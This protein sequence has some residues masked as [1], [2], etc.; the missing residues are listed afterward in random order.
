MASAGGWGGRL[1]GNALCGLTEPKTNKPNKRDQTPLTQQ[2]R[3]QRQERA[4]ALRPDPGPS[5]GAGRQG[6][7]GTT[8]GTLL[9]QHL[10]RTRGGG[11]VGAAEEMD[12]RESI[13]RHAGKEDEISRL[14]AAYAKTQPAPIFAEPSED[15]DDEE[16]GGQ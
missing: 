3:Q 9:T 15:E 11:L 10:L 5:A 6:R 7:I 1:A 2:Q 4:K 14:T 16:E 13:L 8:G 12:A